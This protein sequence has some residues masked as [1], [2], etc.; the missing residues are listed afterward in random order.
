MYL[1]RFQNTI[2]QQL[3]RPPQL[4]GMVHLGSPVHSTEVVVV[5]EV[6]SFVPDSREAV[7]A[8]GTAFE[9]PQ[10]HLHLKVQDSDHETNV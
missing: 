4:K 2:N 3:H 5:L 10:L 8:S 9:V 6:C 1:A 7:C